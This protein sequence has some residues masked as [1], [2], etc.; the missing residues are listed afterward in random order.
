M[1]DNPNQS[2]LEPFQNDANPISSWPLSDFTATQGLL[3]E[4]SAMGFQSDIFANQGS[5]ALLSTVWP[6]QGPG[7]VPFLG[8]NVETGDQMPFSSLGLLEDTGTLGESSSIN[9]ISAHNTHSLSD[10]NWSPNLLNTLEN[11]LLANATAV[12]ESLHDTSPQQS[13]A[14][15]DGQSTM[16]IQS[17]SFQAPAQG[18]RS[19]AP[20][21]SATP[22][23]QANLSVAR[24]MQATTFGPLRQS[25]PPARRGG[26]RGPLSAAE[27]QA[28]KEARKRG[29][30]IR[31][32]RLKQKVP[33]VERSDPNMTR[34]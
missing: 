30:C 5:D 20:P 4:T 23:Q 8:Y 29:V 11:P 9:Q 25:L 31:C 24:K 27:R 19:D 21:V 13:M 32:R 2:G 18:L 33:F 1:H 3:P 15:F 26:R 7:D 22:T 17:T 10:A 14:I 16:P 12:S 28:R 6:L 34:H